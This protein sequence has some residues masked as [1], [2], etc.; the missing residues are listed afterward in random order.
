M[1]NKLIVFFSLLTLFVTAQNINQDKVIKRSNFIYISPIDL[2]LKTF[3]IGYERNLK[4]NHA[5]AVTGGFKF[6]KTNETITRLGGTA[7]V[8][9][10]VNLLYSEGP[11]NIVIRPYSVF[12][13]F[14]PYL[15]YRYEEINESI[16]SEVNPPENSFIHSGFGG[17]GFG[18]RLTGL[19]NRFSLN[20]Y[21]GGGLK[22]SDITGDQK[23]NDFWDVGYTGFAPKLSLQM[24]I[25]F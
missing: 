16:N 13:Y 3:E 24:G 15:S 2:F 11:K 12:T 18:F 25:T 1:K 6:D 8:Q 22:Y 20:A 4:N 10:K 5:F 19:E 14:A 9:Y 17:V 7:E 23:Y 21:A